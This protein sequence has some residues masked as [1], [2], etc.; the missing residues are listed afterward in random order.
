MGLHPTQHGDDGVVTDS[1]ER[2]APVDH[3]SQ[4]SMGDIHVLVIED[5]VHKLNEIMGDRAPLHPT[6]L[7]PVH[8]I[9]NI[10]QQPLHHKLLKLFA[11]I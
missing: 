6:I 10:A 4:D 5:V 11:Q 1:V 8:L 3:H 9:T 7:P 2:L